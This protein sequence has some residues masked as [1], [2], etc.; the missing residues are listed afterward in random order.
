M[1]LE[2]KIPQILDQYNIVEWE[3]QEKIIHYV[4]I[5]SAHQTNKKS[6]YIRNISFISKREVRSTPKNQ[7]DY[8][9]ETNLSK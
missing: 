3:K 6:T 7:K 1:Q 2:R 8:F 9:I 5:F 4:I